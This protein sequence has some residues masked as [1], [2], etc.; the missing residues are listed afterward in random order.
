MAQKSQSWN[1]LFWLFWN[2][3]KHLNHIFK[4]HRAGNLYGCGSLN[5]KCPPKSQAFEWLVSCR[6]HCRS[7]EGLL[8]NKKY[9]FWGENEKNSMDRGVK[10]QKISS[11]EGLEYPFIPM[12]GKL[13]LFNTPLQI[14]NI[15]RFLET[16]TDSW[17]FVS[18][19]GLTFGSQ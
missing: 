6:W 18:R 19:L 15:L 17:S 8:K 14:N 7:K 5:K 13:R 11:I 2:S 12:S 3:S 1:T 4:L 16:C 10:H 9:K